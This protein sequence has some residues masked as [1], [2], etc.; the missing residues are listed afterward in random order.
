MESTERRLGVVY[1]ASAYVL[2]GLMPVYLKAVG[3]APAVEVVTARILFSA[4]FVGILL[5]SRGGF[6]SL[7]T[8]RDRRVALR[9]VAS[10]SLVAFNWSLYVVAVTTDRVVDASL[11]YFINPLVSVGLAAALLGERLRRGQWVAVGL[12]ALGVVFLVLRAGEWPLIGIALAI[13]FAVYGVLRK[14]AP[15]GSLEG[16]AAE[17]LLL[18]PFAACI[19]GWLVA[20]GRSELAAG[21]LDLRVLLVLAG[22]MTAIPL[23]LFA[24]GAR[25]IPLTLVGLLQYLGPTLQMLLGVLVYGEPMPRPRLLGF[26]IVW[27]AL[28]VYAVEGWY[29][30]RR[31]PT[32]PT[33]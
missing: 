23:L 21:P 19:L 8:L 7:A 15:L 13:T 10:A 16:L 31:A 20:T 2:W 33:A 26:G 11:G 27:S 3:R 12:A 17:T 18:S 14:T 22:P 28:A 24:A 6:T 30:A 29:A 4:A 5:A 9:F 25:R 1:A 32:L